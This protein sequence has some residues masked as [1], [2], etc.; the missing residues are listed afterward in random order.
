MGRWFDLT[1][2][3]V[4]KLENG[5]PEQNLDTL[6]TYAKILKLPPNLLWF[7]FPGQTRAI[8]T[9]V[10]L[11]ANYLAEG[12][13]TRSI[14]DDSYPISGERSSVESSSGL[15][16]RAA[17]LHGDLAGALAA[18]FMREAS[19]DEWD[20]HIARLGEATRY[21]SPGVLLD[22]LI[23]RV[24]EMRG[25]MLSAGS[26]E[27]RTRY[28]R[29]LAQ[30]SGLMSLTLLKLNNMAGARDWVRTAELVAAEAN[31][32]SLQSW[33][34]AQEAYYHFYAGDLKATIEAAQRAQ[35]TAQVSVGGILAAAVE[36]R[37]HGLLGRADETVEAV[38]RAE[39]ILERLDSGLLVPSAF[40]YDLAQLRFHQGNA[41]THLKATASAH[42]ALDQALELYPEDDY[43]DRA[44]VNLDRALCMIHDGED[45]SAAELA[46]NVITTLSRSQALGLIAGR[47]NEV[48]HTLRRD[49]L[50]SSPA[51]DLR[52]AVADLNRQ[53]NDV[54]R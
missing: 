5:K 8:T 53:E 35:H 48:L 19:I 14:W 15:L 25:L 43:M 40:G 30:L 2:S 44:L 11:S 36:A 13:V 28:A 51:L 27:R 1:Q 33:T 18:G 46:V 24:S 34:Y 49:V 38:N 42:V 7:D 22:D 29:I 45:G 10:P 20:L 9:P 21:R 6:R 3:Q 41:L 50:S 52:D 4:S 47:A 26:S 17:R 32:S 54:Q 16:S 23:A 12:A 39:T 31:D 37:A